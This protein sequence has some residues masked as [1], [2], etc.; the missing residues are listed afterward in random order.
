MGLDHSGATD[1]TA[2]LAQADRQSRFRAQDTVL[3]RRVSSRVLTLSS[4]WRDWLF[5]PL[6]LQ[7]LVVNVVIY[8][9]YARAIIGWGTFQLGTN[10]IF[11]FT[12]GSSLLLF[13]FAIWMFYRKQHVDV[14]RSVLYSV[15]LSFAATSLFE[16][17]YQN[18]GIGQGI[19]N[20]FME[21]Q[22]INL[23]AILFG[24]SSVR[25]WRATRWTL[26]A[27]ALYLGAWLLWLSFGYP[28][29]YDTSAV[30]ASEGYFF[31]VA[32]KIGSY[33]LLALYILPTFRLR[34]RERVTGVTRTPGVRQ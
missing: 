8:P 12:W 22:V 28:Q 1:D 20:Q 11:P 16:L 21:G 5:V 25:F 26:A 15:A 7:V 4:D 23:S 10:E 19:G 3:L 31:N 30:R 17:L 34:T 33:V 18:V 2:N 32:I 24:L 27:T 29:W 13:L 14:I 6:T 9:P